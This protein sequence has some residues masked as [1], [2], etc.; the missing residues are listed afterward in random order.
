MADVREDFA[1]KRLPAYP[2]AVTLALAGCGPSFPT[3]DSQA[4]RE[5]VAQVQAATVQACNY[6]PTNQTVIGIL[7]GTHAVVETAIAIAQQICAAVQETAP[8][9]L[10][11]NRRLGD[12]D[13]CPMVRGV[14]IEGRFLTKPAAEPGPSVPA[15]APV[16]PPSPPVTP[17]EMPQ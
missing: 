12:E 11:Q 5:A 13:Q 15:P 2:L 8:P 10:I 4:L 9:E 14:C 17:K 16:L 6:L 1:M 3:I 7:T